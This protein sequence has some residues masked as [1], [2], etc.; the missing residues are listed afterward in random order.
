MPKFTEPNYNIKK[1]TIR[2]AHVRY[3]N[4]VVVDM[5]ENLRYRLTI[6]NR[7]GD[8]ER[9]MAGENHHSGQS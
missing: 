8:G 6:Q 5:D 4:S 7:T 2:D 3:R 1:F 9:R